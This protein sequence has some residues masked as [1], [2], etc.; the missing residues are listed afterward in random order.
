M[1]SKDGGRDS[2]EVERYLVEKGKKRKEGNFSPCSEGEKKKKKK[3]K[4]SSP[5]I[6][7][8]KRS[9]EKAQI[10][11]TATTCAPQPPPDRPLHALATSQ[12]TM[13]FYSF[14]IFDRHCMFFGPCAQSA[15]I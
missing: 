1:S 8:R 2:D 15:L 10:S 9:P 11:F 12:R 6:S 7:Q 14:W 3:K 4:I 13:V 5:F